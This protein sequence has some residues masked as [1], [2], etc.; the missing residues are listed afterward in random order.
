MLCSLRFRATLLLN[1]NMI[2]EDAAKGHLE[3]FH[4]C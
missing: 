2:A 3:V 4:D 1:G